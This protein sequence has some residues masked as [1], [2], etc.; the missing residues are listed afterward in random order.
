MLA[1]GAKLFYKQKA[2]D[3][4]T[5]AEDLKE[6]PEM[7]VEPEKVENTGLSDKVKQYENGVG[8]AG[9]LEY[10]F[11]YRND[12][13][14][15]VYRVMKGYENTKETITFK[16]ELPDGTAFTFDGQVSTKIS[17]GAINGVLELTLKIT[18]QSDIDVTDPE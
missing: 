17:G 8:D 18:L 16:Q 14:T 13:A 6:I 1:N 10:K 12:S 3:S 9:D 4:F 5:E 15:C 2:S 11:K 7:G